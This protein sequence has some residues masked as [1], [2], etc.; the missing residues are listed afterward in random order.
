VTLPPAEPAIRQLT[1]PAEHRAAEQLLAGLW[2][3][4]PATVPI[5][6]DVL[7]A[8]AFV[9]AYV[10]GV[11]LPSTGGEELVAT[12]VGFLGGAPRPYLHS[13]ITGVAP[14]AQGRRIGYRLKLD[15]RDWALRRGIAAINWTFDPLVRRNA[16]FNLSRL[17]ATP[18]R[19]LEDFY[20]EMSDGVNAGQGSDRLLLV[21]QLDRDRVPGQEREPDVAALVDAGRALLDVDS[22]GEPHRHD[23]AGMGPLLCRVP[24]DI[25][26]LRLADPQLGVRWRVALRDTMG[27]AMADGH[28][29]TGVTRSGWYHL[30]AP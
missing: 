3:A 16:F 10:A 26:S 12:S 25:E 11:F 23:V 1:R 7:R 6:A 24:D 5:S 15:Q 19:Y 30:A 8:L 14:R 21:W 2:R 28:R 18:T 20:G 17:G 9:D 27:A 4:G 13:H 22:D 29:I